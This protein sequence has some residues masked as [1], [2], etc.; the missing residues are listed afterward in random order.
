MSFPTSSAVTMIYNAQLSIMGGTVWVT[1][2]TVLSSIREL[3]LMPVSGLTSGA[4]PVLSYNYGAKRY[5]RVR[6]AIRITTLFTFAY[7]LLVWALL[8]FLPDVF[9]RLFNEEAA[10]LENGRMGMRL[11]FCLTMFF[12]LQMAGQFLRRHCA[13][14]IGCDGNKGICG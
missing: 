4:Q 13:R 6:E 8:M 10:V 2:M 1:V 11:F 14:R 7:T 9:I 3:V 5:D 12:S